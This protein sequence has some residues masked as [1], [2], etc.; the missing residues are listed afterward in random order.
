VQGRV[1]IVV[2]DGLATGATMRAAVLTL[3]QREPACLVVGVPTAAPEVCRELAADV[4]EIVCVI[5]PARFYGVGY[6]YEDFSAT[7]D[8][9]VRHLL[10]LAGPA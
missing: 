6:W 1:V 4:D 9:E 2:D 7:S 5:T 8:E 10:A 3:R